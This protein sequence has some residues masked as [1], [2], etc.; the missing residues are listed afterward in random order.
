M[1]VNPLL[2]EVNSKT[3][4]K[5]YL[6]AKGIKKITKYL[7]PDDS[8]FDNP[9]DYPNMAKGV[10][11]L[12]ATIE[13]KQKIGI[14]VDCDLDGYASSALIALFLKSQHIP[15]TLYFHEGKEHGLHTKEHLVDKVIQDG[16]DLLIVPDAGSNDIEEHNA[17]YAHGT[18]VLCLD[19]H[20]VNI[21]VAQSKAIII[22]H[23]LGKKLNI[24][25]S[26]AG[27]THKFI[28]EYCKT[29]DIEYNEGWDLVATSIVSDVCDLTSLENRA[30]IN[31][32]FN[33]ITNEMLK[34]MVLK[35]IK[36]RFPN[37]PISPHSI[38]WYLAPPINA[39]CRGDNQKDKRTFFLAL[40]GDT[41]VEEGLK[42]ARR[43]HRVQ[44]E[45]IKRIYEEVQPTLELG[46][47][48]VVGF[49]D[50]NDKAYVGLAAN[51]VLS[52]YNKPVI[53]LREAG[54]FF[55]GSLRSSIPLSDTINNSG[56]AKSQGHQFAAGVLVKK[57]RLQDL[58]NYLDDNLDLFVNPEQ[59][60]VAIVDLKDININLC[61]LVTKWMVLFGQGVEEPTFYIH[62]K[63][64]PND[65]SIFRKASTTIKIRQCGVD[66]M[67][68]GANVEE[69]SLLECC[70]CDV[71]AIVTLKVNEW[72]GEK[73]PQAMVS[74]WEINKVE[75]KV[76]NWEDLF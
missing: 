59:D 3:F 4:I 12:K 48:V 31:K 65:V 67:K 37:D 44:T 47:K 49:A 29:Y 72:N 25:L 63:T 51:K 15:F 23:H 34:Y 22:N 73:T 2:Q 1:K 56:I 30:Y 8:C 33:N 17:L 61:E 71:E 68:F 5:D 52:D 20:E 26:G 35:L 24:A 74:K 66:L 54:D 62:I 9:C 75:K 70:E 55:S 13:V 43:A 27:V 40:I 19:H 64:T 41:T 6:K 10:R 60:V 38:A 45:N 39:L 36:G 42:V 16:I 32:G 69:A 53:L 11:C 7:N 76:E 28:L 46:H 57:N 18:Q 58:V 50:A 14:L 21:E